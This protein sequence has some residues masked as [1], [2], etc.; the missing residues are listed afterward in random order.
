MPVRIDKL[1]A[2]LEAYIQTLPTVIALRLCGSFG[3]G[4]QCHINK[5][6]VELVSR[7]E[8]FIVEP[9]RVEALQTWSRKFRCFELKCDMLDYHLTQVHQRALL[10][11]AMRSECPG[12]HR[13]TFKFDIDAESTKKHRATLRKYVDKNDCWEQSH[14]KNRRSWIKDVDIDL[15]TCIFNEHQA[16]VR[17]HFGVDV[18][19]SNVKLPTDTPA[20]VPWR[21]DERQYSTVAYITLPNNESSR[22]GWSSNRYD[23]GNLQSGYAMP[24][25]L[26][27]VPTQA[28]LRRFP[29]ALNLLGLEVFIH[30]TQKRTVMFAPPDVQH[31]DVTDALDGSA[32]DWPQLTLLTKTRIQEQ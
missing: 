30:P 25:K 1:G 21:Y 18:W 10:R 12:N 13:S 4:P 11:G 26:G 7:I 17:S 8:S 22:E 6:P 32:A 29:R 15:P 27:A 9:A 3:T 5:L 19:I 14:D 31:S 2:H 23:G 24:V 20:A 28:S 16:L